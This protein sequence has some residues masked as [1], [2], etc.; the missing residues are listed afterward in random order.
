MSKIVM[1]LHL[2]EPKVRKRAVR[3]VQKHRDKSKYTRKTKH[4]ATDNGGLLF[5]GNIQERADP[6][7]SAPVCR[8]TR[9]AMFFAE[10]VYSYGTCHAVGIRKRPS[11]ANGYRDRSKKRA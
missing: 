3:A 7:G 8:Q 4:R 2:P 11:S 1:T 6:P 10:G 9:K 5:C